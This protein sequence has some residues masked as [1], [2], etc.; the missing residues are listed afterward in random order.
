MTMSYTY[1][2]I[3]TQLGDLGKL[4]DEDEVEIN[5]LKKSFEKWVIVEKDLDS[6]MICEL[7]YVDAAIKDCRSRY[8]IKQ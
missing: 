1:Y 6:R 7:E 4:D 5:Y 3:I 2:A 8:S